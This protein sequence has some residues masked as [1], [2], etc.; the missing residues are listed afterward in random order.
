MVLAAGVEEGVEA[1]VG[2]GDTGAEAAGTGSRVTSSR[3]AAQVTATL[4]PSTV[5]TVAAI[6]ATTA[7]RLRVERG[8]LDGR[9][10]WP[11][12]IRASMAA[13]SGW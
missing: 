1:A 3:T 11:R 6:P 13:R 4:T 7:V 2:V 8:A 5:A 10:A 12:W 9:V